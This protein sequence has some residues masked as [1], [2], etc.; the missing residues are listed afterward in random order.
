MSKIL[1]SLSKSKHSDI[2]ILF[3]VSAVVLLSPL[4]SSD[5]YLLKAFSSFAYLGFVF[6]G[7]Y[8]T[9]LIRLLA[10]DIS[11]KRHVVK[12]C[13]KIAKSIDDRKGDL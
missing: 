4:F 1:F 7:T 5:S 2:D 8:L 9:S 13:E 6:T 11:K 10:V 12:Q 3:L